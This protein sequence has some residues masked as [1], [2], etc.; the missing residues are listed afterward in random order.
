[1]AASVLTKEEYVLWQTRRAEI[2]YDN[3]IDRFMQYLDKN[4]RS[5][6]PIIPFVSSNF[7]SSETFDRAIEAAHSSTQH[8][9]SKDHFSP[10]S[11]NSKKKSNSKTQGNDEEEESSTTSVV[12]GKRSLKNGETFDGDKPKKASASKLPEDYVLLAVPKGRFSPAPC[13]EKIRHF[14]SEQEIV[15]N[16]ALIKEKLGDHQSVDSDGVPFTTADHLVKEMESTLIP[17]LQKALNDYESIRHQDKSGEF[18]KN[19]WNNLKDFV[20]KY[21]IA[22]L[23]VWKK[24]LQREKSAQKSLKTTKKARSVPRVS[25]RND[26]VDNDRTNINS[27]TSSQMEDDEEEE[28][29]V[30]VPI[31]HINFS[32]SISDDSPTKHSLIKTNSDSSISSSVKK[33][34][35]AI[36]GDDEEDDASITSLSK[37]VKENEIIKHIPSDI[38][39]SLNNAVDEKN[40]D[41]CINADDN[42]ADAQNMD[43]DPTPIVSDKPSNVLV[44]DESDKIDDSQQVDLSYTVVDDKKLKKTDSSSIVIVEEEEDDNDEEED[45]EEEDEEDDE[46]GENDDLIASSDEEVE[47]EEEEYEEEEEDD[48]EDEEEDSDDSHIYSE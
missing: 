26:S 44:G 24:H 3:V 45:D 8:H 46:D 40:N 21:N 5:L 28:Q 43:V 42:S 27:E 9:R 35:R 25:D 29:D 30:D 17:K 38:N 22:A 2:D 37:K 12:V 39:A 15:N 41:M 48:E 36:G 14:I 33:R 19:M 20:S 32:S 34:S 23:A 47:E 16:I 4:H 13:E 11:T 31:P 18:I 6:V 7:A 10:S 1:M